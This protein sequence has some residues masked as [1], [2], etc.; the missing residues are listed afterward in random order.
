MLRKPTRATALRRTMT[1]PR[2]AA[3]AVAQRVLA[4]KACQVATAPPS[5]RNVTLNAAAFY[6]GSNLVGAGLLNS[7]EVWAVLA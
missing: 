7:A 3:L 6:L 4:E 1:L 2:H 5:R